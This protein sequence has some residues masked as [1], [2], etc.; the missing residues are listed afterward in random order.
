VTEQVNT[1]MYELVKFGSDKTLVSITPEGQITAIQSEVELSIENK[2]IVVIQ[3]NPVITASGFDKLNRI[4]GISLLV[5]QK[6]DMPGKGPQP[7]P[8]F[9][10]DPATGAIRLVIAK[11]VAIGF[12]S[13]G[14][15]VICEQTLIFDLL[16]Y[17]KMDSI[18]KIRA[19]KGCGKIANKLT[20]N[21]KEKNWFFIPVLDENYGICLDPLHP[22]FINIIKEHTQRQRFAERI[23]MGILKRNCLRHHPAIGITNVIL[24]EG[25]KCKIPMLA[26]RKDLDMEELRKIAE[27]KSARAGAEV[28]EELQTTEDIKTVDAV[29]VAQD[30]MTDASVAS[31]RKEEIE[32]PK[33]PNEPSE[34]EKNEIRISDMREALGPE[35]YQKF[36]K[37]MVVS[38]R[39]V[40]E[41]DDGE[42]VN[43]EKKLRDYCRKLGV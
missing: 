19:V 30:V 34:R 7:N 27:D 4:A 32:Q 36:Y 29:V 20:L 21:D 23:A 5:P 3:G 37:A 14:N 8:Y 12:S 11:M 35:R 40:E 6:I 10:F 28:I 25:G 1:K 43:Y 42:I 31:G 13:V 26:W 2:D 24:G 22:E 38:G 18:A 16:S 33:K 39:K 15:L 9:V 17:F 41:F